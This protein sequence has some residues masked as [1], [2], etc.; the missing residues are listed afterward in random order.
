[1]NA[2]EQLVN[3]PLMKNVGKKNGAM[4]MVNANVENVNVLV[5]MLEQ[6][7]HV[8]K[9]IAQW[10]MNFKY[11]AVMEY[12]THVLTRRYLDALARKDG[13]MIMEEMTVHV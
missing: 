13:A 8:V 6:I 12:A 4:D 1:M 7:A 3:P 5:V 9:M 11:A 2:M 10:M